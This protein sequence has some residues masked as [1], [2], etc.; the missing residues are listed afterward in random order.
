MLT[1]GERIHREDTKRPKAHTQDARAW[2]LDIFQAGPAGRDIYDLRLQSTLQIRLNTRRSI[3]VAHC[4]AV[5][6][7]DP[8]ICDLPRAGKFLI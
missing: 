7:Y 6:T 1:R 4:R 8:R 5:P 3:T 2:S